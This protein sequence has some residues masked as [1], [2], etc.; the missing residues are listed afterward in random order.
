M[1]HRIRNPDHDQSPTNYLVDGDV[2]EI[3]LL[4]PGWQARALE[5]AAH[6][7]GLTAAEMVR[8]LLRDF[9]AGQPGSS[10]S[11]PVLVALSKN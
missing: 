9:I 7:S 6:E 11:E 8:V 3:P 2:V 1:N 4:L 5:T 10:G